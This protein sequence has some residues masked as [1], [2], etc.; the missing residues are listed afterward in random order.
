[1]AAGLASVTIGNYG[2]W[3][4]ST[5]EDSGTEWRS[6]APREAAH[7]LSKHLADDRGNL[8]PSPC[9]FK[10][11]GKF[12]IFL[13]FSELS[14]QRGSSFVGALAGCG[15]THDLYQAMPSGIVQVLNYQVRLQAARGAIRR[16]RSAF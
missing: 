8:F 7:S 4:R 6:R 2:L 14:Q 10:A 1:M 11:R 9:P 5:S 15:K 3:E 16:F 13:I 12:R